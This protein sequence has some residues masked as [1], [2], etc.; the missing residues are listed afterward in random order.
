MPSCWDRVSARAIRQVHFDLFIHT[1]Q[2]TYCMCS[3]SM[4]L[5]SYSV[6]LK[7]DCMLTN[8]LTSNHLLKWYISFPGVTFYCSLWYPRTWSTDMPFPHLTG[9]IGNYFGFRIA[10]FFVSASLAGSFSRSLSLRFCPPIWQECTTWLV[11]D[12]SICHE[13]LRCFEQ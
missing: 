7:P 12:V 9:Q 5:A 3:H 11:L 10:I 13:L 6:S 8:Y 1:S 2:V 4:P